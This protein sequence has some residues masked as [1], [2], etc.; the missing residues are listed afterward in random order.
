MRK[1]LAVLV[2]LVTSG[3]ALAGAGDPREH[4]RYR[5]LLAN[6]DLTC[7]PGTRLMVSAVKDS[8]EESCLTAD[9]VPH[10]YYLRWFSDGQSW[11]VVGRYV[12]GRPVGR[13]IRLSAAGE[14]LAEV[15]LSRR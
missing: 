3:S 4:M 15:L 2:V 7:P 14:P 12:R 8:V 1:L 6:L 11:A 13:W 5:D 9:G 10:G